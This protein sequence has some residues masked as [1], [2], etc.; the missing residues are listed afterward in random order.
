MN[1]A[2]IGIIGGSGLYEIEGFQQAEEVPI[3]TPFGK[4]SDNYVIGAFGGKKVAF[5]SRHGRG[6][7]IDPSN[8]NYRANIWGMKTLG[9]QRIISVSAVGS[10]KDELAPGAFV[11][12]DQFID[13]TTKRIAT[14]FYGEG[15]VVHIPFGDPICKTL[16]D[17]LYDATRGVASTVQKNGI[18]L[19][20]EGP[21]FST[22]AESNTYRSWGVDVIGMTNLAEAKLS[23]EAEICYATLALVTDYDCWREGEENVNVEKVL[24]T[25]RSNVSRAKE[26]LKKLIPTL[27]DGQTCSCHESLKYGIQTQKELID[28]N[29]KKKFSLL[30]GKYLK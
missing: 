18:Y 8:I 6:H 7:R 27:A 11:I 13:R 4:P 25:I 23:R 28:P 26:V 21:Q 14:F 2:S 17:S 15:I 19:N 9:V 3:D 10:M 20:M 16:I 5:L 30:L 24:S 12:P 22:R 1:K 29:I